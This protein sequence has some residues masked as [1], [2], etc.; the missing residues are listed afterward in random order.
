[1][2][3]Q[4]RTYTKAIVA[5]LLAGLS[6]FAA[7]LGGDP[8]ITTLEWVTVASAT[9]VAFGSVYGVSN[10]PLDPVDKLAQQD[11]RRAAHRADLERLAPG[12]NDPGGGTIV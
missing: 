6:A 9:V 7:A 8:A 12:P 4:P 5:G 10:R 3:S 1:M 11:R 2:L